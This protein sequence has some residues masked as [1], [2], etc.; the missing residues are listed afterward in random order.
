MTTI[1]KK[2][3]EGIDGLVNC[4]SLKLHVVALFQWQLKLFGLGQLLD[5]LTGATWLAQLDEFHSTSSEQDW[6]CPN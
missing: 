2:R 1:N 4:H 5:D 6:N 3:T